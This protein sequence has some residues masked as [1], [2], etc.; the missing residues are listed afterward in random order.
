V[1]FS[2]SALEINILSLLFM[3]V[4]LCCTIPSSW[5]IDRYGLKRTV[6][7]SAVLNVIGAWIRVVEWAFDGGVVGYW[8]VFAGSLIVAFGQPV[9]LVAPVQVSTSMAMNVRMTMISVFDL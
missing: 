3:A 2:Q 6:Q 5:L 8:F 7:V 9:L 4:A 1:F